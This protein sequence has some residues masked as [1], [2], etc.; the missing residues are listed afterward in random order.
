M[1]ITEALERLIE[2]ARFTIDGAH[3]DDVERHT[4]LFTVD[5]TEKA[6]EAVISHARELDLHNN[7]RLH[8]NG[9]SYSRGRM[10]YLQKYMER[11]PK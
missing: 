11:N 7:H 2:C 8:S 9:N 5:F 4:F 10:E 6:I 1:D 3:P